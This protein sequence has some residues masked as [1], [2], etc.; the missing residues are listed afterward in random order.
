MK[1][2]STYET[3][4]LLI[5]CAKH[6]INRSEILEVKIA[7]DILPTPNNSSEPPRHS[8]KRKHRFAAMTGSSRPLSQ[9]VLLEWRLP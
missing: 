5:Y 2:V 9:M 8:P 3:A 1:C 6:F 7:E 4:W